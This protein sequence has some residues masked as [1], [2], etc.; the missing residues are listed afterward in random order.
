MGLM[1]VN[2]N[3]RLAQAEGQSLGSLQAHEQGAGQAWPARDGD[4]LQIGRRNASLPHGRVGHGHKIPQM[5]PRGQL[6]HDPAVFRVNGRLRSHDIRQN[7]AL[8]N[9]GHTGLITR[10][11]NRE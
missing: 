8:A 4:R 6:R 2:V 9:D 3:N 5:F 10:G 11:L 7:A 1:M